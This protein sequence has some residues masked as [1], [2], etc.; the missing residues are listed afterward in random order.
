MPDDDDV[1]DPLADQMS[2][3]E[4]ARDASQSRSGQ[5]AINPFAPVL[6]SRPL[7]L[8]TGRTDLRREFW[9]AVGLAT[10]LFGLLV[11]I[12]PF[13][14]IVSLLALVVA[15]IRVPIFQRHKTR[16]NPEVQ[17]PNA[18]AL[19]VTS[20]IFMLMCGFASLVAFCCVCIP[21]GLFTFNS[22]NESNFLITF[23]FGGSGLVGLTAFIYLFR[24]SLRLAR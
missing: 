11:V 1:A 18:V 6:T 15:V 2:V 14:G 17:L 16:L 9:I 24:L 4:P 19:L 7:P 3:P 20:W 5:E 12:Q 23:V 22:Y 13:F 10:L 21:A 8:A